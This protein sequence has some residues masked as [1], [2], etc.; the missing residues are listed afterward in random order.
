[1][2]ATVPAHGQAGICKG[3]LKL[4]VRGRR[5]HFGGLLRT[6][7]IEELAACFRSPIPRKQGA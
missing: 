5:P 3:S 4:D 6:G 1:M 7:I 2:V